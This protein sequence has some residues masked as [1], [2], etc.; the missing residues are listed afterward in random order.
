MGLITPTVLEMMKSGYYNESYEALQ[1]VIACLVCKDSYRLKIEDIVSV[2]KVVKI[3]G[4]KEYSIWIFRKIRSM[5]ELRDLAEID[6]KQGKV[7]VV[8]RNNV[9]TKYKQMKPEEILVLAVKDEDILNYLVDIYT[10]I[11][12]ELGVLKFNIRLIDNTYT[13]LKYCVVVDEI[14][15]S[16]LQ[17]DLAD[18]THKLVQSG[19][20]KREIFDNSLKYVKDKLEV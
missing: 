6:L 9:H 8:D 12:K 16:E 19:Y 13:L 10:T 5:L 14:N 20:N 3:M 15:G 7:R 17:K 2:D 18:L 4:R 1:R 11:N